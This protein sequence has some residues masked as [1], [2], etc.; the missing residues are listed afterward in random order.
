MKNESKAVLK[1][2]KDKLNSR[3]QNDKKRED[4]EQKHLSMTPCFNKGFT[5]IELL[6]VVLIIG[7]LSA[8]ALPQYQKSV[9]RA[10]AAQLLTA[11]KSY[12][13]AAD[14]WILANGM[15]TSNFNMSGSYGKNRGVYLYPNAAE[16]GTE[17]TELDQVGKYQI[18]A[19]VSPS[20]SK[21]IFRIISDEIS[22]IAEFFYPNMNINSVELNNK[23]VKEISVCE[24]LVGAYNGNLSMCHE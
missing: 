12:K 5:L 4:A 22:I 14:E 24:A 23:S 19:Y 7:I 1:P 8:V 2:L 6:V 16:N 17:S 3:C 18:D 20:S 9:A 13:N 11:I 21:F 10:D 15:P